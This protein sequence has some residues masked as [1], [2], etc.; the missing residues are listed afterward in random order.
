MI[1]M[2]GK[3]R[4][5]PEQ[6]LG[7]HTPHEQVRPSR[8]TERQEQIGFGA[9]VFGMTVRSSDRETG[10]ALA[11][12]APAFQLFGQF[13]GG[14]RLSPFVEEDTDCAVRKLGRAAAVIG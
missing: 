11:V 7:E 1:G 6:L 12:V 5:R 2:V 14:E 13:D 8:R 3:D 4:S 9:I 10:L